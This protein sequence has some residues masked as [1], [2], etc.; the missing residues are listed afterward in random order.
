MPGTHA[1]SLDCIPSHHFKA[2]RG[3]SDTT[4][5][6]FLLNPGTT[7]T[8]YGALCWRRL[9]GT[10]QVLLVTSRDTGRWV[11]PKGWPMPDRTPEGA[12]AREAWEEAGVEGQV[13]D[14]CIGLFSYDKIISQT[15]SVPC[16]VA[17][18]PLRVTGLKDRF[19]ERKIRRRKWF[20]LDKAARKVLEPELSAILATFLPPP[21]AGPVAA[22]G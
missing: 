10:L 12:A 5:A 19:P 20:T 9:R 4:N 7:R 2:A 6:Q 3:V 17:V 15:V 11:V 22:G 8:Q 21:E 18:Y 13:S 1:I 16:V 14:Q